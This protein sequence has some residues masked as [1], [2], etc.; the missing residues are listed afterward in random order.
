[1]KA[2]TEALFY[3]TV[4]VGMALATSAFTMVAGLFAFSSASWILLSVVLACGLCV[5]IS[6]SIGELASMYPSAPG[7]RTY[8]K[9]AF[10]DK[11]SLVMTYFYLIFVVLIAGLESFVFSQVVSSIF[12]SINPGLTVLFLLAL[13]V[14]VNL[15]GLELPR[16]MQMLTTILAVLLITVSG[17]LGLIY[18]RVSLAQVFNFSDTMRQ[19][20]LLP[21]IVGMSIFLF[22]G[23][24]WVTPLGLRPKAYERQIPLSMPAT[25][26]TLCVT[27]SLFVCGAVSQLP[28]ANIVSTPIPQ[29][30]YFSNL[31][32]VSGP[33]LALALS[34]SAIF[35]T[36]NAGIMG[37]SK[38][39]FMLAREGNL[40]KWVL[41][42][43]ARTGSPVGAILLLGSL[44][45]FSAFTVLTFRLELV[46]ALL[47]AFIMC[48][49]Y[50]AFMLTVIK[51]RK[52]KPEL[53]RSFRNPVPEVFQWLM[54]VLLLL[55]GVFTL[56]SEPNLRL[57]LCIGAGIS[58]LLSYGL[59]RQ[60]TSR[61]SPGVKLVRSSD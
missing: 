56:L 6:L 20:T 52:T 53:R 46:A 40:P 15:V 47:G 30:A 16:S 43:S 19:A 49:I 2:R 24:E 54:V 23:F 57:Q 11:S 9:V 60:F 39:L 41:T 10:G 61:R 44:A 45:T 32:G 3:L 22:T 37:G 4:G 34:A 50:A 28:P 27:Y 38:L 14:C 35:S 29:V 17:V 36:F 21:A 58:L 5:V 48:A 7:I 51:L 31:Y 55:L 42:M 13:V 33:Y 18:A 12:P 26:I 1:M 8:F 59:M 25:V